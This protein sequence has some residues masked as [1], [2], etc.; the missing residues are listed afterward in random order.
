[1][2][3]KNLIKKTMMVNHVLQSGGA[4]CT[5]QYIN[6]Y[7]PKALVQREALEKYDEIECLIGPNIPNMARV[8]PNM[9]R[10][11]IDADEDTP[12]TNV[13]HIQTPS[14]DKATFDP[15][16]DIVIDDEL[17]EVVEDETVLDLTETSKEELDELI[18]SALEEL[19]RATFPQVF[20][21]VTGYQRIPQKDFTLKQRAIY[22][23]LGGR[24]KQLHVEGALACASLRKSANGSISRCIYA[25]DI[26]R[27]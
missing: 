13:V 27:L 14:P 11:I 3:Q 26:S 12:E 20:W 10:D 22:D 19:G 18:L 15:F 7:I 17:G 1:M 25:L 8:C 5:D 6:A 16:K 9:V 23:R 24:V 21:Y 2:L 4:Y